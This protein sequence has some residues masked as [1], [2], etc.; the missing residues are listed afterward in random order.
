[1]DRCRCLTLTAADR[2]SSSHLMRLT[3]SLTARF[4][5]TLHLQL[6]PPDMDDQRDDLSALMQTTFDV[7]VPPVF[8]HDMLSLTSLCWDGGMVLWGPCPLYSGLTTLRFDDLSDEFTPSV[9]ELLVV[10]QAA[11]CLTHLHLNNV[12]VEHFDART[13]DLPIL[14]HLSHL[15]FASN[16]CPSS[17][18]FLSLLRLPVMHTLRLELHS[19]ED[20][21]SFVNNCTSIVRDVADLTLIY[22]HFDGVAP[23]ARLLGS[24]PNLCRLDTCGAADHFCL[25]LYPVIMHWSGVCPLLEVYLTR[26]VIES[27]M[28]LGMLKNADATHLAQLCEL[29]HLLKRTCLKIAVEAACTSY[30]PFCYTCM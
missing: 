20:V 25:L 9:D 23:L 22:Q 1:M 2:C 30:D 7:P 21:N 17:S 19:D 18:A 29:Y 14:P 11:S 26:D 15:A 3:S 5:R 27:R 12:S 13:V 28:M 6:H 24:M 16:G 8:G 4:V 10:F